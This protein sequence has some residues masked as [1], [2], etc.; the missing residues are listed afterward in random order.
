MPI[1]SETERDQLLAQPGILLRIATVA[2]D[3]SPL[4]V[5]IWF[6]REEDRIYFTPRRM[7]IWLAHIR[8]D[9]RVALCIDE[10][11]FPYR[12]VTVSG[13][14]EIVHDLGEDATWRDLYRRIACRYV[15]E[16]DADAYIQETLDQQRALCAVSL[17]DSAVRSWRMPIAEES[18]K[19][20]WADRYYSQDAK[21][22]NREATGALPPPIASPGR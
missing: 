15:S 3:G 21:I 11:A 4:C 9:P 7:S 16:P 20:I 19:G 10:E 22:R 18:Y 2:E 14:A 12:K 17:R 1:M 5:P 6:L 13:R 8:V